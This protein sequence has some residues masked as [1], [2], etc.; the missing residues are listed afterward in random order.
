[1][2]HPSAPRPHAVHHAGCGCGHGAASLSRRRLLLGSAAMATAAGLGLTGCTAN[3]ATGRSSFT[4]FSDIGD[5]VQVGAREYPK[6]LEA[7]GGP[8]QNRRLQAYVDAI[9]VRLVPH[10]E[11]PHLPWQVTIANTPIVN[12]FALPG[13]KVTLTR[14]LL[15][16]ASSEAEVAGVLAHEVGHVTARHSAER[17]GAGLLAQLGVAVLGAATGSAELANMAG[18]GAQVYLRGYSRDQEM[19]ADMLGLRYMTRA[20]YD[21]D[22]MAGFL[23]TLGEQSRLE[24]RMAG[25]DP[26]EADAYNIMATHPRSLDRVRQAM[27]LAQAGRPPQPVVG[28]ES[29]LSEINGMLFGEDPEQ[30]LILD[31][32]RRF[33]H[34]SLRFAFEAPDGFRLVNGKERVTARHP[35]GA[36]AVL[37]LT[38]GGGDPGAF[39]ARWVGPAAM[40]RPERITFNGLSAATVAARLSTAS[41]PVRAQVVAVPAPQPDVMVRFLFMASD[42][43]F[44]RFDEAFRRMTYSFRHLSAEEASSLRPLRLIVTRVEAADT[45][46]DLS[47]RLPY[48]PFNDDWFR[49][50]NDLS[51]RDGLTPGSL[52]KI[53]TQ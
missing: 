9:L 51:V 4:A 48:G 42:G 28:R 5:D 17:Q 7:F 12:A 23:A 18:Q 37:D 41:G 26:S 45:V 16:M 50:L 34:P 47:A 39:V 35:G 15:A 14:G 52:V 2:S 27:Q 31:R 19:E 1:M 6:L 49:L 3:P 44:N 32:G 40:G 43:Q 38:R 53:V 33:A 13:G 24:A 20:G 29:F 10:T 36:T 46:A 22:A 25:R 30:G 8:Y 21:P 11:Y